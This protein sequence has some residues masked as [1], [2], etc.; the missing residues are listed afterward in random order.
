MVDWNNGK[1]NARLW[2]LKLLHD[3]FGPG[4]KIVEIAPVNPDAPDHPYLT[5]LAM[6]TRAGKHKMLLVN[7]RDRNLDLSIAGAAGGHF[8]SVDV[9]TGF[10]PPASAKVA[11]EKLMIHGFSVGVLTFP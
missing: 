9:T 6:V 7:K 10:Q 5:G 3:N 2:V 8:D 1:P 11:S 4:D